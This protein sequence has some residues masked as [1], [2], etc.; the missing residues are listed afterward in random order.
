MASLNY[1][2][3]EINQLYCKVMFAITSINQKIDWPL[4]QL[5]LF[6]DFY[7]I[8]D[9]LLINCSMIDNLSF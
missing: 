1:F 4:F 5:L 8:I 6:T 2:S 7:K 9:T 3:S